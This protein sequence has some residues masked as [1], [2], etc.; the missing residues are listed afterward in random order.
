MIDAAKLKKIRRAWTR[1]LLLSVIGTTAW[2]WGFDTIPGQNYEFA[3]HDMLVRLQGPLPPPEDVVVVALDEQTFRTFNLPLDRP[4]PRERHAKL[5]KRLAK[6]GAKRVVFDIIFAGQSSNPDWDEELAQ[7]LKSMPVVLGVEYGLAESGGVQMSEVIKP[8]PFLAMNTA[9]LAVTAMQT[10]SGASRYFYRSVD[11]SI[12]H[13]STLSEAGGGVLRP[14]MR[15]TTPLP[16]SSD[17]ITF[18]G[19]ARSIKTISMYQVLEEEVPIPAHLIKDKVVFVGLSMRTGLGAMQKDSFQTPFGDVFGVEIHATQAA[20]ILDEQWTRRPSIE[21]QKL[22]GGILCFLVCL[23]V[24]SLRPQMGFFFTA[25]LAGIWFILT[26]LALQIQVFLAGAAIVTIAVPLLCL[27][28]TLY[29]YI[30]TRKKQKQIEG[31]F[32]CYLSPAMVTQLKQNPA[33]LKLGGEELVCSAIF[34]DIKG[35]TTISETLGPMRV[36]SMLNS[37]FSD[38]SDAVTD[39][40]GT[41]IKFIGDAVFALWGAP[42]AQPDHAQ[43][44]VRAALK[45]Q[46][47]VERFN[48]RGEYPKLI[49]RVGVNTGKMVVGNLGS[50]KRFDYTAIGDSV[51]LAARVEGVNKYLGSTVLVTQDSVTQLGQHPFMFLKMGAIRVVG[52]EIPVSLYRLLQEPFPEADRARWEKALSLFSARAWDDAERAFKE[53]ME[54]RADLAVASQTYCDALVEFRATAPGETWQGELIMDHK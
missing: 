2:L 7:S 18:Y 53:I 51:N 31:A 12:S 4:L 14:E 47:V 54:S 3:I 6:L 25:A 1:R 43:R 11:P 37:Y 44:A 27:V 17:L 39:E 5:I 26:F 45:I 38:V 24:V 52:K 42:I 30:R 34:T 33:L 19:P 9:A 29:W 46:E 35:F 16:L 8:D 10:E 23:L 21:E 50:S 15:Q 48:E 13:Y 28:N 32:A 22:R 41:V 36:V 20:N 49:T 40:G